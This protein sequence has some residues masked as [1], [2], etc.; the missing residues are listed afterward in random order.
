MSVFNIPN[1]WQNIS[2]IKFIMFKITENKVIIHD[3]KSDHVTILANEKVAVVI[4]E[5]ANN[6]EAL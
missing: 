6:E 2:L 3:V 5:A 4:N 1:F